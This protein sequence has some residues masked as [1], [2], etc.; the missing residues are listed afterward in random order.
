MPYSPIYSFDVLPNGVVHPIG[1]AAKIFVGTLPEGST[2]VVIRATGP[3]YFVAD[4][5]S[6][7]SA[8]DTAARG[9]LVDAGATVTIPLWDLDTRR[10]GLAALLADI[11]AAGGTISVRCAPERDP[12][13]RQLARGVSIVEQ[14]RR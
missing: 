13:V 12:L 2:H 6:P 11:T 10:F 4:P 3:V 8:F 5:P 1:N 14:G 9:V 7:E